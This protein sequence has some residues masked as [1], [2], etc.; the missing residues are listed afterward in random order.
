MESFNWHAEK[1]LPNTDPM[2][3]KSVF[4]S[5]KPSCSGQGHAAPDNIV[6]VQSENNKSMLTQKCRSTWT[7]HIVNKQLSIKP[8]G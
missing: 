4:S 2:P 3:N 6:L 5:I 7:D 8:T 1:F